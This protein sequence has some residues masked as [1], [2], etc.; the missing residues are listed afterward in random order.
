[1]RIALLNAMLCRFDAREIGPNPLRSET[2]YF[3][4]CFVQSLPVHNATC[5]TS[6][7]ASFICFK[8]PPLRSA[9]ALHRVLYSILQLVLKL[10]KAKRQYCKRKS[11]SLLINL[12][13]WQCFIT[14]RASKT[15][16]EFETMA[17]KAPRTEPIKIFFYYLVPVLVC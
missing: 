13:P 9:T 16:K 8:L 15:S 17:S 12:L 3:L 6:S 14:S 11:E 10:M 2:E 4:S 7:V 5:S 1:M